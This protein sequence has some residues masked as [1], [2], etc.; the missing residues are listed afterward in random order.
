MLNHLLAHAVHTCVSS[1]STPSMGTPA[2]AGGGC[3][4]ASLPLGPRWRLDCGS[5][6]CVSSCVT[7]RGH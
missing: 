6:W 5:S 2:A 4:G 7:Y 1:S 3:S